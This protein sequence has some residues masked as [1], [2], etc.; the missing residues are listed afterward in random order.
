[1]TRADQERWDL[2]HA[3]AGNQGEPSA[4]LKLVFDQFGSSLPPGRAMDIACGQG[5]NAFFLA[6]HG[7]DVTAVDI[8]PVAL[9]KGRKRAEEK[10]L[11]ISWQQADLEEAEWSEALF[12]LIINFNYLQRSLIAQIKRSLKPG[13]HV[14]FETYLIDQRAIGHPKHPAYLLERNELLD[15]FRGFRV[16]C[17]REGKFIEGHQEMYRA[18]FFGQ[19]ID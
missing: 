6:Q 3:E 12:D 17:F 15:L 18:G 1:M 4:F 11:S 2:L 5:R 19:K 7:F 10:S 16:L 8:S 9:A 14:I 13:A